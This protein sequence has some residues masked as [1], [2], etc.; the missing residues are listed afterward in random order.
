MGAG[1]LLRAAAAVGTDPGCVC[2]LAVAGCAAGYAAVRSVAEER[3]VD[4]EGR[5]AGAEES[6]EIDGRGAVD[7][8]VAASLF[9]LLLYY[10]GALGATEVLAVMGGA[11]GA[12][13]AAFATGSMWAAAAVG[14]TWLV[15]G[16]WALNDAM[17]VCLVVLAASHMRLPDLRT[18]ALLLSLLLVYD[19]L[20]VYV[21]PWFMPGGDSV[22][23][24]VATQ[25]ATSPLV[26]AAWAAGVAEA[27]L[28]RFIARDLAPPAKL[29]VPHPGGQAGDAIF[30]GLGDVTVPALVL[31]LALAWDGR[32]GSDAT[33]WQTARR[34]PLFRA[35]LVAYVLSLLLTFAVGVAFDAAQPAL[36]FI[37]PAMLASLAAV[38]ARAGV[39]GALWR[40]PRPRVPGA[41][42]KRGE[43]DR[44][45]LLHE[46]GLSSVVV[47]S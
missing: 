33:L 1:L 36:F 7:A 42:D 9:L 17:G 41:A 12:A 13:G 4:A 3:K 8:P 15:T 25:T 39:L 31:S 43:G 2:T 32:R 14:A 16:H 35:S 47:T 5:P 26:Q 29:I 38:A 6:V 37:V 45:P 40:G 20:W 27:T 46:G 24:A 44:A 22:M 10:T 18:A 21:S 30:L 23:V 19:V 28:P 34:G 11:A